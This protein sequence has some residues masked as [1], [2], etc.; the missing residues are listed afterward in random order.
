[1]QL[2]HAI[3]QLGA[4]TRPASISA[5]PGCVDHLSWLSPDQFIAVGWF[6]VAVGARLEA[7]L[8]LG[9]QVIPLDLCWIAYPRWDIPM[10][11]AQMGKVLVVRVCAQASVHDLHGSLLIRTG[12]TVFELIPSDLA[13][14][15]TDLPTLI[16]EGLASLP[17]HKRPAVIEL[18]NSITRDPSESNN[19]FQLSK[20]LF[21]IREGLRER[22]SPCVIAPDRPQGLHVESLVAVSATAFYLQGWMHDREAPIARLTAITPEGSRTEL[23]DRIVCYPRPDIERFYHDGASTRR[24]TPARHGFVCYFETSAPSY[25]S[26]GWVVELHNSM[27]TA[28]E[29]SAPT[30]IDNTVIA[31]TTIVEGLPIEILPHEHLMAEHIFPAISQLQQRRT[32]AEV[33]SITQYGTPAAAPEVSII[34]PLYGRIDFVEQQLAQFTHDPQLA[35]SDLIYVLDSPELASPLREAAA[36]LCDL[37]GVP[38]RTVT[39]KQSAG[40]SAANNAGIAYARGRLLLLLNSDVLPD[41]PGW[42]GK[43]TSFYDVTPAIGALGPKL[44]YEDDALQHAGMYFHLPKGSA[45]AYLWQNMHYFKGLHRHLPA[46]NVTRPVPAVT[47]ACLLIDAN[48]YRRIGGFQDCYL[49]GDHEDSD[50]CLRLIAAGYQNWYL[51][52][53]ELYHLEGQSYPDALRGRNALYNRWLHTHLWD[54]RIREVMEC[55]RRSHNHG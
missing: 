7:S 36:A 15:L 45:L 3:A 38:F 12:D 37:Y 48:L 52:Q 41:T 51:P 31:R 8:V 43:L 49:Q 16:H 40:F 32:G 44:L 1:M 39:L 42:L 2:E 4:T 27:G 46:A 21:A 18:L 13:Q 11:G 47:G 26:T 19:G 25:L 33:D 17:V 14:A 22:L 35:Q 9:D 28:I 34:V 30:A 5:A 55:Y 54:E 10:A 53:V 23:I 50:L 20:S 29:A 24:R 6:H